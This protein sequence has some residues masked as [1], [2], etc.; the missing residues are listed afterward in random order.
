MRKCDVH[1]ILA[2]SGPCFIEN[3]TKQK[4]VQFEVKEEKCQLNYILDEL[5]NVKVAKTNANRPM[6]SKRLDIDE[7]NTRLEMNSAYYLVIK[8]EIMELNPGQSSEAKGV[9][10][11]IE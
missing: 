7:V 8:E 9:R 4:T 3:G 11:E 1:T 10:I 6:E 2:G 5:K